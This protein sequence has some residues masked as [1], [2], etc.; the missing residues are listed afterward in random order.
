MAKPDCFGL[1][2]YDHNDV[3]CPHMECLLRE[4]CEKVHS[5]SVGIIQNRNKRIKAEISKEEENSE[6]IRSKKMEIINT[7]FSGE[8][9]KER[10]RGY[11]KPGKILYKDEGTTRDKFLSRIRKCLTN[12]S[13]RV[14]ATKCIHSFDKGGEYLLKIDT[15]RKK[16]ILVFMR[17]ELSDELNSKGIGCRGLYDSERDNYPIYITWVSKISSET[18][19]NRL[20]ESMTSCYSLK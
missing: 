11:K 9:K 1:E 2:F 12:N 4:E 19:M 8:V 3:V 13:Y 20:M 7:A 15:R 16:S 18:D 6:K 17:D 10:K 14:R 5:A